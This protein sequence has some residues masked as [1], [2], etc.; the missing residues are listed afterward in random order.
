MQQS[1]LD[2]GQQPCRETS[3]ANAMTLVKV[4]AILALCESFSLSQNEHVFQRLKGSKDG[5]LLPGFRAR[6]PRHGP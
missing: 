6:L 2:N 5:F 4:N 3:E 1:H